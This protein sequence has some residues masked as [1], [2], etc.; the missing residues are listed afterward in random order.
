[1]PKECLNHLRQVGQK[2][3]LEDGGILVAFLL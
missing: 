3:I 2:R 1:M